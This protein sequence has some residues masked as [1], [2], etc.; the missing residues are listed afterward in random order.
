M[1]T[2]WGYARV[3][4]HKATLEECAA[5]PEVTK[6]MHCKV[7]KG[8]HGAK[9]E[10]R[11]SVSSLQSLGWPCGEQRHTSTEEAANR[12]QLQRDQVSISAG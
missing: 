5:W 7:G 8:M 9:H 1:K 6:G 12:D 4:R 2:P 10:S 11:V 3:P